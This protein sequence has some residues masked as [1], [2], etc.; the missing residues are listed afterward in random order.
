[1]TGTGPLVLYGY[2]AYEFTVETR[3]DPMR[4]GLLDKGFAYAI[5]HVRG[6]GEMGRGWYEQGRQGQKLNTFRDFVAVARHLVDQGYAASDK[7]GAQGVS[8]GGLLVGAAINMEPGL[9]RAV[10][11]DVPF[12]DPLTAGLDPSAPLTVRE[13]AEWGN[14]L[15]D[16]EV[17]DYIRSY[18]PYENVREEEYPAVL[19]TASFNDSRVSY[20][21]AAKWVARLRERT[22]NGDDRPILLRTEMDAGH[23]GVTGLD[24]QFDAAAFRLAWLMAQLDP[25]RARPGAWAVSG[26]E[27]RD[28]DAR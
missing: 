18:S 7:V 6:G 1:M 4:V 23:L 8:A 12:V 14:P 26:G 21:E 13:W 10:H 24:S 5:A 25:E 27:G 20:A 19:A 22:T 11:A 15:E 28:A 9:F 3:F 16:D 17:Y 2:G